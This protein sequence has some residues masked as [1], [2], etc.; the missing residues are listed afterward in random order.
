MNEERT[1]K[2]LRQVEHIRGHLCSNIPAEPAYGVY[3]TQLI[4]YVRACGS[5]QDFLGREL[6]LIRNLPNQGFLL[7]K[8]KSLLR[9][10][11]MNEERTWKC[12]RQV[13]HIRGH[14]W[15]RYSIHH[16]ENCIISLVEQELLILPEHMSSPPVFSEVH[17]TWSL[18]LYVCFLDRC[19]PFCLF[20]F[21]H[22]VVCSSKYGFWLTL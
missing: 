7:V 21:D 15:H 4:R 6:L 3:I 17:V 22:C 14:L 20:S 16:L 9:K 12:L 5:Y 19:L 10:L 13:E 8:L 11:A 2:C 18:V 1:G